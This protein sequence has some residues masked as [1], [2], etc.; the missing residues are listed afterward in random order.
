MEN[1]Q[2]YIL[3]IVLFLFLVMLSVIIKFILRKPEIEYNNSFK[4]SLMVHLDNDEVSEKRMNK[5]KKIYDKYKL[6]INIMKATHYKHDKEELKKYPIDENSIDYIRR[7]GAYGLAGSL[8]KCLKKAHDENWPYLLFLEDDAIPILPPNQFFAKFNKAVSNLPNNG[9][10][11][12]FL[13]LTIY[14][15]DIN[16]VKR[17]WVK[18]KDINIET[19]GTHSI[20]FSKHSISELMNHLKYNKIDKAI[21]NYIT[22]TKMRGS[23]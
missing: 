20:L 21:D 2:I 13:G 18:K 17:G 9:N 8:Y 14:C 23:G 22:N 19:W 5:L 3:F 1:L 16:K 10:G 15:R 11:I 6:P 12:Y 7:P 4:Y